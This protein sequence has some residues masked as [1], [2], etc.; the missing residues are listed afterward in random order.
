MQVSRFARAVTLLAL[1][2]ACA[3]SAPGTSPD[4]S[5]PRVACTAPCADLPPVP[6]LRFSLEA[7]RAATDYPYSPNQLPESAPAPDET[8]Y[9]SA[10]GSGDPEGAAVAVFWNVQDPTKQYLT[11]EPAPANEQVTFTPTKPG[12]HLITLQVVELAGSRQASQTR[13][14]LEV[15]PRPCA[16][17]GVAAPCADLLQVP[18]GAFLMGSDDEA[19]ESERPQHPA[20]VAA[21]ALDRYETTVGRF[22]RF[23]ADYDATSLV[24]GQGAHPALANSGW[25]ATWQANLPTSAEEFAFAIAECG[26]TWTDQVGANEARPISCITWY[27]AFA[28]CAWEGKRLPTE[29]EW[30]FAAAG[31]DDQRAF[32]WGNEA[33][34]RERAV[35]GCLFDG[36]PTCTDADLPVAGSVLAGVGRF[37]QLDLAGSLW[38]WTL[39]AFAPYQADSCIDCANLSDQGSRVFRGGDYKFADPA[40]LK[41]TTRYAFQAAFPDP[42]RGVRCAR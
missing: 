41:S 30:E 24:E 4:P 37:G 10:R 17:D 3:C 40:S 18:G 29:L 22:R 13:L 21:F 8:L 20:Q 26:G 28:F 2:T 23:L 31:G 38:E 42:T 39:D 5:E 9:L 16:P 32:P 11:L 34:S 7:P 15:T 25:R 19:D 1:P 27:E 6:V 33:P 12:P 36:N 14:T 35:F